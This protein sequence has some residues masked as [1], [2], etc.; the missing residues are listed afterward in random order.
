MTFVCALKRGELVGRT[1]GKDLPLEKQK[2]WPCDMDSTARLLNK[3]LDWL[4]EMFE[5]L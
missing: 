4:E 5:I 1:L 3:Q 2:V